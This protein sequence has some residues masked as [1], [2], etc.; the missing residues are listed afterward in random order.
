[1]VATLVEPVTAGLVATAFLGERLGALG[2]VG[3]LLV[4]VAIASLGR[5]GAQPEVEALPPR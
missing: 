1:M 4:L 5:S 3:M 2:V